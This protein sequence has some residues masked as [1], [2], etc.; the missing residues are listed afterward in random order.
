MNT[1]GDAMRDVSAI[2]SHQS[3]DITTFSLC[4]VPSAGII[5]RRPAAQEVI[6]TGEGSI[7]PGR[8]RITSSR[9]LWDRPDCHSQYELG[10][11]ELSANASFHRSDQ[12]SPG[13]PTATTQP[14]TTIL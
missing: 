10:A 12:S 6:V 14:A 3:W 13:Q 9:S 5:L 4:V 2:A 7:T 1:N 8:R 11:E